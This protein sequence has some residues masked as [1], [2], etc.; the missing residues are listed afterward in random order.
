M[1][2]PVSDKINVLLDEISKLMSS[3][4]N[5][6]IHLQVNQMKDNRWILCASH[7]RPVGAWDEDSCT[8]KLAVTDTEA[9]MYIVVAAMRNWIYVIQKEFTSTTKED[10]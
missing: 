3:N 7:E 9:T 6:T 8:Y 2:N 4:N 5:P 1:M 10:N